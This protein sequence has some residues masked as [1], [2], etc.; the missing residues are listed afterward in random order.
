MEN[1]K[2]LLSICIP[3]YNRAE[4]LDKCLASI[5]SQKEFRGGNVE[6]VISDNASTDNTEDVVNRY[7]EQYDNIFYSRNLENVC[8]NNF[9]IVIGN[10]DGIFRKLCNDTII[11]HSKAIQ[12]ML[13]IIIENIDNKPVLFFMNSADRKKK[14]KKYIVDGFD[15]FLKIASFWTTWIASFGIWEDDFMKIKDKYE[16]CSLHLWQ[17]KVLFELIVQRESLIDNERLF[18]IQDMLKKDMSYGFFHVF[19]NNYLGLNE[20]YLKA[21]ILSKGTFKYL[22]KHL[23]FDFFSQWIIN[24]H[25][26]K[27]KYAVS[28]KNELMKAIF[29]SYHNEVYY[30]LF[31]FRLRAAIFRVF[32]RRSLYGLILRCL[33]QL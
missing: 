12:Y 10:A 13:N 24:F 18:L 27:E 22:K 21:R 1:K 5:V 28:S 9:P 3:T 25:F 11:F 30:I 14:K 19:Y 26:H 2:P 32:I 16:G 7:Q 15:S 20:P 33:P 17:T 4:Y 6:I 29:N 23:L 8:D 31:L